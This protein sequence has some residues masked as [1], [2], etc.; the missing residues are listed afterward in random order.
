MQSRM[1]TDKLLA[2]A[3]EAARRWPN[4]TLERNDVGNLVVLDDGEMAAWL[5]LN[6]GDIQE[7]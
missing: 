7:F 2:Q 1:T 6:F 4:A 5:D 3:T